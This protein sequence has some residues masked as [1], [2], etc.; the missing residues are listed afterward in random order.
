MKAKR[1]HRQN[2]GDGLEVTVR[3]RVSRQLSVIVLW[4]LP[5]L[6]VALS[7]AYDQLVL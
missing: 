4:S 1:A 2:Q 3:L 7:A 5:T 6:T